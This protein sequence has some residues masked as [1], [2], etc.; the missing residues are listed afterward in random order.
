M[1][2]VSK[3]GII[4]GS[5]K[6]S[7]R[8]LQ[9]H[10]KGIEYSL[11]ELR[12]IKSKRKSLPPVK[13]N[14]DQRII[15]SHWNS[16]GRPFTKHHIDKINPTNTLRRVLNS[17]T[18]WLDKN[19]VNTVVICDAID[20]IYDLFTSDDFKYKNWRGLTPLQLDTFFYYDTRHINPLLKKSPKLTKELIIDYD[21]KRFLSWFKEGRKGSDY[22]DKKFSRFI[23]DVDPGISKIIEDVWTTCQGDGFV[24]RPRDTNTIRRI[25]KRAVEFGEANALICPP[26]EVAERIKYMFE[27]LHYKPKRLIYLS[28]DIFWEDEFPKELMRWSGCKRREI[29]I[30]YHD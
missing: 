16:K 3:S 19:N 13:I 20:N 29:V 21:K 5:G 26:I 24:L 8:I 7:R 14:R 27:K 17:I 18:R 11:M 23:K 2:I 12:R 9:K 1:F 15:I 25:T 22:L 6:I 4:V 28:T 10:L 30:P